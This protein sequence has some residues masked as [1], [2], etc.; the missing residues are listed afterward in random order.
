MCLFRMY[1]DGAYVGILCASMATHRVDG[2]DDKPGNDSARND[3]E[4]ARIGASEFFRTLILH[5]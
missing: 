5:F 2:V 3:I 4:P 1:A